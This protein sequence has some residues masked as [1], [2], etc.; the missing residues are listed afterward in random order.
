MARTV[1][2]QEVNNAPQTIAESHSVIEMPLSLISRDPRNPRKSLPDTDI[3]EMAQTITEHG[4]ISPISI[5][6]NPKKKGTYLIIYGQTRHAASVRAEKETIPSIIRTIDEATALEWMHIENLQRHGLDPVDEAES[7][8]ALKSK[9]MTLPDIMAKIGKPLNWIAQRLKI[10]DM[11]DSVKE[12]L[13]SEKVTI[14]QAEEIAKLDNLDQQAEVAAWIVR[15][16]WNLEQTRKEVDSRMLQLSKAGWDME[17]EYEDKEGFV[18]AC[19]TCT[20]RTGCQAELFG[21]VNRKDD[22][23]TNKACHARKSA[24]FVA[25]EIA[26]L[27]SEKKKVVPESNVNGYNSGYASGKDEIASAKAAKIKPE[28]VVAE[29]GKIREVYK[30]PKTAEEKS[31]V[32]T[33]EIKQKAVELAC[34][35]LKSLIGDQEGAKIAL[36]YL[37]RLDENDPGKIGAKDQMSSQKMISE[38]FDH[39]VEQLSAFDMPNILTKLTDLKFEDFIAQ[40]KVEL[41]VITPNDSDSDPEE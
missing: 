29:N 31:K 20:T 38:L 40:A 37:D 24:A 36:I 10:A 19:A 28:Y 5:R 21:E 14:R 32:G 6:E 16:R 2:T 9:R 41:G 35:K 25:S 27:K 8:A 11:P 12:L 23:C 33:Y 22:R 15:Y 34:E 30:K 17:R 1:K 26:R 7:L 18:P 4:V 13:R 3:E 39:T